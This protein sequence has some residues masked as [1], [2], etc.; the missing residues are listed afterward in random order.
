MNL[1]ATDDLITR[2]ET[3]MGVRFPEGLKQVWR[4]SNGLELPG[5]WRL[6]PVFDPKEP[7]KTCSHVGRENT[8]GRWSYM[9]KNLIGIAS[10]DTGNQLV[11][12][13]DG[14]QL[15]ETILLWNHE[16]NRTRKWGK[17]FDYLMGKAEARVAKIQKQVAKSLKKSKRA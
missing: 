15:G 4:I 8:N 17:G 2:A 3:E 6:Y 12:E 5:G 7:R 16:T 13:S 11:L 10:G 14:T 1:G 9:A